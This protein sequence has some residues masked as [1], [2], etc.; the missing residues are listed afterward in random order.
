M[1][2]PSCAW[3]L[4]FS[5]AATLAFCA[6]GLGQLAAGLAG[7]QPPVTS[8]PSPLCVSSFFLSPSSHSP[9][10]PFQEFLKKEFSAENVTF[11]QAC[12]RFQQIPASDT[13]QVGEERAGG[14]QG[15]AGLG[16]PRPDGL[17][18]CLSVSGPLLCLAASS[19]G[20]Q[21]LPGVPVEPGAEPR[22]HRSA[23]L[24]G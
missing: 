14:R 18:V 20:S 19:R 6:L 16:R 23:G 10:T 3:E 21:H 2:T 5:V 11:W 12:E 15:R 1:G 24:A 4:A 9:L 22:E 7:P 13:E 17:S 8:S